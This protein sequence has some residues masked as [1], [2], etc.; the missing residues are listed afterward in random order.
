MPGLIIDKHNVYVLRPGQSVG[1]EHDAGNQFNWDGV[2]K[3][4]N[5]TTRLPRRC[6]WPKR[7]VP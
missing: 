4:P 6:G 3:T 5:D 7:I 2:S 1:T